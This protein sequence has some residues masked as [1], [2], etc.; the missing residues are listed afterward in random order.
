MPS[1]LKRLREGAGL[2]AREL[3]K[4]AGMT[5]RSYQKW[6]A[7]G[8]PPTVYR[9]ISIARALGCSVEELSDSEDKQ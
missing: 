9:A 6:E 4:A 2:Y 1:K 7:K 5:L 8:L 3:S